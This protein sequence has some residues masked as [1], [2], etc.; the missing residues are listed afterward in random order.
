MKKVIQ[1][2]NALRAKVDKALEPQID[3]II[4]DI[5]SVKMIKSCDLCEHFSDMTQDGC[6]VCDSCFGDHSNF[7]L[8]EVGV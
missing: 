6:Q 1:K 4:Q 8:K 7:K 5:V 3:S 2:L